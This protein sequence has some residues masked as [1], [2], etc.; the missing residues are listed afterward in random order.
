MCRE[1]PGSHKGLVPA[2]G[3]LHATCPP[4]VCMY[5]VVGAEDADVVG[6]PGTTVFTAARSLDGRLALAH[7]YHVLLHRDCLGTE[8]GPLPAGPR[9]ARSG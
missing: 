7:N 1:E 8:D 3:F 6:H 2:P 9:P 5:C 4:K